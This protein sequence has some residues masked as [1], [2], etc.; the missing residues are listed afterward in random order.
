MIKLRACERVT[1]A[2]AAT[3]SSKRG[4]GGYLSP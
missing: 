2:R 1:P 3:A 4:I